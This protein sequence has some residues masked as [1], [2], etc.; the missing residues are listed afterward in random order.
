MEYK[1]VPIDRVTH[2]RLKGSKGGYRWSDLVWPSA[3]FE[4]QATEVVCVQCE[5]KDR[6]IDELHKAI[7]NKDIEIRELRARLGE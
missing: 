4:V 3:T 5:W 1:A 2:D 7:V 6:M